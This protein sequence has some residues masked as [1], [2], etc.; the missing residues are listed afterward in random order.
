MIEMI[1]YTKHKHTQNIL[2]FLISVRAPCLVISIVARDPKIVPLKDLT[3]AAI[4]GREQADGDMLRSDEITP[5]VPRELH[6]S[7]EHPLTTDR[8][9]HVRRRSTL[10]WPHST[11]ISTTS[12]FTPYLF[13]GLPGPL[14]RD[15]G[16]KKPSLGRVLGHQPQQQVLREHHVLAEASSFS[17]GEDHRLDRPL[18]E[19][20]ED[21]GD[22]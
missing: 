14:D 6:R 21:G 1:Y 19:P 3:G 7:L 13:D 12:T 11:S 2:N 18:G 16:S 15:A 10:P 5:H 9:R 4:I 8:E 22:R 20:L 17:L